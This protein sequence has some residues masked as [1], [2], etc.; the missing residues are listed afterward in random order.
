M[1]VAN[2][3]EEGFLSKAARGLFAVG[4]ACLALSPV[5][6]HAQINRSRPPSSPPS[7]NSGGSRPASTPSSSGSR[8]DSGRT[9]SNSAPS[10]SDSGR[11]PRIF[12]SGRSGG[13][14]RDSSAGDG[15][16]RDGQKTLD[17]FKRS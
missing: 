13:S 16:P 3:P 17:R 5:A 2:N 9:P 12:D 1:N 15:S 11:T 14:T 10:K 8:S 7:G 6:T 4:L